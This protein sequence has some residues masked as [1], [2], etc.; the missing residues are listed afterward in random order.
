[1]SNDAH[2]RE[3]MAEKEMLDFGN[4]GR[5]REKKTFKSIKTKRRKYVKTTY[6]NLV[7]A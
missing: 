5:E 6:D 2:K 7:I 1:M 4:A 3:R